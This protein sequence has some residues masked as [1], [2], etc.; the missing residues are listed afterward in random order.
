MGN[1]L[2]SDVNHIFQIKCSTFI[3]YYHC[4]L[5]CQSEYIINVLIKEHLSQPLYLCTT[6]AILTG[7]HVNSLERFYGD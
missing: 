6:S 3:R 2:N 7:Y 5:Q 4:P 1:C